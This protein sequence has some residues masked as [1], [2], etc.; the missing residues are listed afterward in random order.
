MRAI[1]LMACV[2]IGLV[3]GSSAEAL[4]RSQRS[5]LTTIDLKS[6]RAIAKNYSGR[7][8]LCKGLQGYPVYYAEGAGRMALSIGPSPARRKAA[9]QTLAPDSTLFDGQGRRAPIEWRG[10]IKDGQPVPY[11]AIVRT[12]TSAGSRRGEVILVLRVTSGETCLVAKIDALATTGA[13]ALAREIADGTAR[14]FDCQQDPGIAG[15][16]GRSPM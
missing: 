1:R 12:F 15:T 2:A 16:T 10:Y 11:A 6:C 14:K 13:M 9:R 5:F 3:A 7:R 8:W 4:V